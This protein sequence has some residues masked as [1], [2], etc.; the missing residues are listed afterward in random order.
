MYLPLAYVERYSELT[1]LYCSE[2]H[3]DCEPEE[4][5]EMVSDPN[6]GRSD[7]SGINRE[8]YL[9][10]YNIFG[11]NYIEMHIASVC[12]AVAGFVGIWKYNKIVY[13]LDYEFSQELSCTDKLRVYPDM[14]KHLPF[15][16][17][18]LDFS[19]NNLFSYEGFFVNVK[20]DKNGRIKIAS[21][22]TE[23]GYSNIPLHK[24]NGV[25]SAYADSFTI[26][27]EMLKSDN[28]ILYC[29][30]DLY[31][32]ML[33][34]DDTFKTEWFI[35]GLSNF[36]IFLLQFLMYLSSK[37]PDIIENAETAKTYKPSNIIKNKYSEIQKWD[38]GCRYGE[39]IR[40]FQ[41]MKRQ[42]EV[43]GLFEGK[44]QRS[45]RPHIRKAHW[46]R[47]HVG[48]GRSSI[49][50][51][52]K[53]STFINGSSEDIISTIHVVTDREPDCSS[54]EDMIKQYLK[55]KNIA[56]NKEHY[57]REIGKRYDFSISIENTL[58][59]IEFDGEQHFKTINRWGGRKAYIKRHQA[60]IEK[61]MYCEHN[62]IPLLRVRF[63]Q[64]FAMTEILDDFLMNY[65]KY[66]KNYNPYLSNETY[67][68]ICE[69]L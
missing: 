37:E 34:T 65:Q 9:L 68:S 25:P 26:G 21:L 52:W 46:E 51:K 40:T 53:S 57:V 6:W 8:K 38:V 4:L 47:Y 11:Q 19:K 62:N 43:V 3:C 36:R 30:F 14:I 31:G 22:P 32:N 7:Y 55:S 41:K 44:E 59:F 60:D 64:A 63:D 24:Y 15:D 20:V 67:Y 16:T 28:G 69:R 50:Q 54:G 2:S 45:K 29:D 42:Q 39:K 13:E 33:Y 18:Y 27:P 56:F 66:Y 61:N 5:L 49:V 48:Q 17:F 1:E 23:S 12:F 58:A 35:G 10:I